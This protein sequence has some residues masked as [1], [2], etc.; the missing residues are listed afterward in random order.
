MDSAIYY[1]LLITI[2]FILIDEI[3]ISLS[4][5]RIGPINL[6]LYGLIT[7][8]INGINLSLQQVITIKTQINYGF[9]LFPILLIII[10]IINYNWIYPFIIINISLS[11]LFILLINSISFIFLV[12]TSLSSNSKYCLLSTIRLVSQLISFE[13]VFTTL[14]I[15][16]IIIS[17]TIQFICSYF[18]I[19]YLLISNWLVIISWSLLYYILFNLL[20]FISIL[21]EFNRVPFDLPEAESELV[22]GFMTEYSSIYFSILVLIEYA[23]IIINYWLVINLM[24]N[25]VLVII[26]VLIVVSLIRTSLTRFKYDELMNIT[27]LIVIPISFIILLISIQ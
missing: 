18:I 6:G 11:L 1:L 5:R 10:S 27:W 8:L 3:V 21:A 23:G 2:Y 9:Q 15:I 14:L 7:T 24:N 25:S 20:L 26:P 19:Y 16:L 4:Q 17:N 22:A 13:L 12:L